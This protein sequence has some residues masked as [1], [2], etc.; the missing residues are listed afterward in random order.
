[1][2]YYGYRWFDPVTGRWP[3]RDPIE[4]SGGINVYGFIQN[5]PMIKVDVIGLKELHVTIYPKPFKGVIPKKPTPEDQNMNGL[6]DVEEL[7]SAAMKAMDAKKHKLVHTGGK[8]NR[9][10]EVSSIDDANNHLTN[11]R[12][13][14]C[15]KTLNIEGHS[16]V[17][18]MLL[19]STNDPRSKFNGNKIGFNPDADTY[20]N[21]KYTFGFNVF[22]GVEWCK[23]CKIIFRGCLVGKGSNGKAFLDRVADATGCTVYGSK[24]EMHP[25]NGFGTSANDNPWGWSENRFS[26][27]S[28]HWEIGKPYRPGSR[29]EDYLEKETKQ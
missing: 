1:M 14:N 18:Y 15:I 2:T 13:E 8:D 29:L 23:D 3:S 4:E 7:I 5:S 27:G 22:K 24:T 10:F 28:G 25:S 19:G 20:E 17:G 9:F 21:T 16:N 26:G 11:C 12:G 6:D